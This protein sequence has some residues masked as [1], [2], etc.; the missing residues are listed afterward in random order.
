MGFGPL[1]RGPV[2]HGGLENPCTDEPGVFSRRS[3]SPANGQGS[4]ALLKG[5]LIPKAPVGRI[6]LL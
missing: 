4:N 3:T 2:V 1:T 6:V 5:C